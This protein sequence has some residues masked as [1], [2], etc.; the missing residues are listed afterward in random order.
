VPTKVESASPRERALR[1][2]LATRQNEVRLNASQGLAIRA[3]QEIQ[4]LPA[5]RWSFALDQVRAARTQVHLFVKSFKPDEFSDV[6]PYIN[7]WRAK[8]YDPEAIE[9]GL[10]YGTEVG[11]A[12]DNRTRWISLARFSTETEANTLKLKLEADRHW[13]WVRTERVAPATGFIVV[14]DAGGNAVARWPIPVRIQSIA[15]VVVS[16]TSETESNSYSGELEVTAGVDGRMEVY[17]RATVEA[18]L[19]GV[20]PAE[21]P[22]LWPGEALKAQAVAARSDTLAHAALKHKLEGFD[23]TVNEQNRVYKGHGARHPATDAA[24]A[25][26]AGVVIT[27]G[28]RIVPAVFSASCGGWTANNET[29]WSAPADPILRARGDFPPAANPALAGPAAHGLARW[30]TT[31]PPAYCSDDERYYRWRRRY[32][33]AELTDF[34]NQR[35]NVGTVKGI[36]LG[37]RGPGGRLTWVRVVGLEGSTVIRKEYPIRLAFGNLPSAQFILDSESESGRALSFTFVGAGRGHGVG[38][39]QHGARGMALQGADYGG[40]IRHYYTDVTMKQVY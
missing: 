19:S 36:E 14:K 9:L 5:G 38:L 1:L 35:H 40:I 11:D 7:A 33:A 39:C 27:H 31:R 25:A 16:F 4:K 29:A 2:Q 17:E 24:V 34:V 15:P 8:G 10:R 21:M 6:T 13:S 37:D 20:L 28:G 26:T 12:L 18:Y 23:F 3:G 30:L 32:T 22:A